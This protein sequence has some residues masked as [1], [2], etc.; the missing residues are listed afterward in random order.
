MERA[1]YILR[2]LCVA[3]IAGAIAATAS[4]DD[5]PMLTQANAWTPDQPIPAELLIFR[6]QEDCISDG[7]DSLALFSDIANYD[8][9][10]AIISHPCD[11]QVFEC[12]VKRALLLV[13]PTRFFHDLKE[14][15]ATMPEL[16]AQARHRTLRDRAE[17]PHVLV[18]AVSI[19]DRD[20]S[21]TEAEGVFANIAAD[22][23]GGG[24]FEAVRKKYQDAYEYAETETLSDGFVVVMHPTRVGNYGDFVVSEADHTARPLRSADLPAPHV[25]PL[26]RGRSGDIIILRDE[27]EHRSILYQV[28]DAYTPGDSNKA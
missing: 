21:H 3:T 15:Y 9:L 27:S 8:L 10:R 16:L 17:F 23:R 5:N 18:D 12:A 14:T 25:R 26:L 19:R 28:R 24:T 22:L 13:G 7:T 6:D 2:I 4:T 20:M 11:E 1:T